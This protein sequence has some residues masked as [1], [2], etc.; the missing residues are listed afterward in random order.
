MKIPNRSAANSDLDFSTSG[1]ATYSATGVFAI[2][3]VHA[4]NAIAKAA[5]I[6]LFFIIKD[7]CPFQPQEEA[8][9]LPILR[10]LSREVM[11]TGFSLC[12]YIHEEPPSPLRSLYLL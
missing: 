7:S 5:E 9:R 6:I 12:L 1:E 10:H 3:G 8:R 11:K 4:E 2:I